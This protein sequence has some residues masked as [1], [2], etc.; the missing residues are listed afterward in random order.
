MD[1]IIMQAVACYTD[2]RPKLKW[3]NLRP[4]MEQF[5][6]TMAA[7]VTGVIIGYQTSMRFHSLEY[8]RVLGRSDRSRVR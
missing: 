6:H 1:F 8:E 2:S 7:Q 3:M 4:S 5:S